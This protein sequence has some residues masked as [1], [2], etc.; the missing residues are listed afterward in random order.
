MQGLP[1]SECYWVTQ[2]S[3]GYLWIATDAGVVKY[4]GYKF[5]TYCTAKGLP[6]NTVFKIHEDQYGKIWFSTFSG[7]FAYYMHKTDSVYQIKANTELSEIITTLPL[8]FTF[9]KKDTLY[10]SSEK[11]GYIKIFPPQYNIVKHYK[12]ANNCVFVKKID[13]H[14]YIYG[15]NFLND[16]PSTKTIPLIYDTKNDVNLIST[17]TSF[18]IEGTGSHI[19]FNKNISTA[20]FSSS[21]C[22]YKLENNEFKK[23]LSIENYCNS[24]KNKSIIN[25]YFDFKNRLWVNTLNNVG[26]LMFT[27]INTSKSSE[28]YIE[29][30]SVTCTIE[31]NNGGIWL[32]TLEDGIFYIPTLNFKFYNNKSGLSS[33]KIYALSKYKSK[34]TCL[35]GDLSYNELDMNTFTFISKKS[36][37]NSPFWNIK[38]FGDLS[39]ICGSPSLIINQSTKQN[40]EIIYK[41]KERINKIRL[42]NTEDFDTTHFLGC[43]YGTLYLINKKT[44]ES[45]ILIKNLPTIFSICKTNHAIYIGTKTGLYLLNKKKLI[46]LGDSISILK[47]RIDDILYVNN[48]LIIATKGY[49]VLIY[50][51]NKIIK[52]YT[53]ND[54][55]ASNII[56]DLTAD[57]YGNIWVGTNRGISRLKKENN[58]YQ[59]NTINSSEGLI[60]SEINQ[61]LIHDTLLF[62]ATNKGLGQLYIKD[63]FNEKMMI[64]TYIETLQINNEKYNFDSTL[65]LAYNQNMIQITY[66]GISVKSEGDICY[67]YRLE[68]LDTN[69]VITKNT[70]VQYTTLPPGHYKFIVYAMNSEGKYITPTYINFII[71]T[72]YWKTLWFT[73]VLIGLFIII[74]FLFLKRR[75]DIIKK[76]EEEKTNF[77]KLLAQSELRGLRS[78]MNPH[79]IF[80]AINSIQNFVLKNDSKSAQK[81]L[82]KFARLIRSVLENSKHDFI[83]LR[84]EIEALELYIELEVLRASFGFDYEIIIEDNVTVDHYYIPPMIIQPYVE[85]SI[86]HGLSAL[87]MRKGKLTITFSQTNNILNCTIDDNGIGRK[88]AIEIKSR[89]DS[90]RKSMGMEVTKDRIDILNLQDNI[91]SKINII[92]KVEDDIPMGTTV[93]IFIEIKKS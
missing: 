79:F 42:K 86:L 28:R 34:L 6:D 82:T 64:P 56:K 40:K 20:V 76:R 44:G 62:F 22:I 85:N 53:E 59:I 60:S 21:D 3:K 25:T 72:P 16:V 74:T 26:T 65:Y 17:D 88:K 37:N 4:D 38:T 23:I 46:F 32:T 33:D 89:K 51:F 47:N 93:E 48:K 54:G 63:V 68:G 13:A 12:Y 78:Q 41:E 90:G 45:T 81:Y 71:K 50:D 49:G 10:I 15:K 66:K 27:D 84:K 61:L 19:F 11:N 36:N 43:Q 18:K 67:K 75:I 52:Q 57:L 91:S 5:K 8:D 35:A 9:D 31:D 2:D 73:A 29:G 24:K 83:L 87:T 39:V 58:S 70:F 30:Y 7:K 55:L 69:W 77:N 1:S 80:N 92:D 14:N